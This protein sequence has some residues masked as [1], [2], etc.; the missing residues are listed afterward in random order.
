MRACDSSESVESF[1][2]TVKGRFQELFP[3]ASTVKP[4]GSF[5]PGSRF[6]VEMQRFHG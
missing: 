2:V 5:E 6:P 1:P 3:V 4:T